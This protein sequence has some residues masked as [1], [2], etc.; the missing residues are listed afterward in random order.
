MNKIHFI[1]IPF[2]T[3]IPGDHWS[4]YCIS[5]III[6]NHIILG[7]NINSQKLTH[8]FVKGFGI[9]KCPLD[10]PNSKNFIFQTN[11]TGLRLIYSNIYTKSSIISALLC[12]C[13]QC[14]NKQ[15]AM[16]LFWNKNIRYKPSLENVPIKF[17]F[18]W[19]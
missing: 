8:I 9:A 17:S 13:M 10:F 11:I 2:P 3:L 15:K 7:L 18:N 12:T 19:I 6:I 5:I 4:V 1:G 14:S 16:K